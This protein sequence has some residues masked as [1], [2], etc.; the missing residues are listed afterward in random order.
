MLE[1]QVAVLSSGLLSSAEALELLASLRRGRLYR[2]D[3]HSYVLYPDRDLPGFLAKNTIPAERV[4]GSALLTALV[5][6][7][8]R[9]LV[10]RDENGDAHFHGDFRNAKGVR[11]ALADLAGEER[12]AALV[13]SDG[14]EVAALFEEVFDHASFTGRSGTFFAYEG[15]GSIYWHMVSKLLL[16]V[17]EGYQRARDAGEPS[18]TLAALAAAYDD[19]RAG[20]GF[21]KTPAEFGAFPTDPYS[22]TPAHAGA[23]QPGMTGQVKEDVLARLGE[24]GVEVRDGR[25]GFAP[26][27]LERAEF[28]AEPSVANVRAIGGTEELRLDAGTLAFTFCQVPV[29]YRLTDGDARADV[30]GRDGVRRAFD[31]PFLDAATSREVFERRS[32][33]A[34]IDVAVPAASLQRREVEGS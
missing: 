12:W 11:R 19:V 2:A 10:V 15:L 26:A 33:V 8:D 1:G 31:G 30:T 22:H 5:E 6:A 14:E 4:A 16:A 23:Q 20:L 29:V 9:R 32:T 3:Q 13:A 28:L 18:A 27:L 24:L 25:L 17:Q 7:G 21:H 34:R